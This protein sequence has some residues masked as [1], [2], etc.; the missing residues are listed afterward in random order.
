MILTSKAV[1]SDQKYACKV[2][3]EHKSAKEMDAGTTE[4]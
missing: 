1:R 2:L 4:P 3:A